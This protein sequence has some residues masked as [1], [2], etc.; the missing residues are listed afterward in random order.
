M[1]DMTC[2]RV[3]EKSHLVRQLIACFLA[4]LLCILGPMS[5]L[6]CALEENKQLRILDAE[7]SAQNVSQAAKIVVQT[8]RI[9]HL[10]LPV[11]ELTFQSAA[12]KRMQLSLR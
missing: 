5:K 4:S 1:P 11:E 6:K 3:L 7:K 9:A 12:L 8:A 2:E 10:E